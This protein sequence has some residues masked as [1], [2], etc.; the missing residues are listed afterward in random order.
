MKPEETIDFHIRWA[1]HSIARL[2]NIEAARLGGSMSVGY[3]LLNID[4]EKGCP[5][6]KLGTKMGME[7][8]SLTRTLKSMEKKIEKKEKKANKSS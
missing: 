3:V 7:P 4:L 5:S 6:T 1:W 8:R 2:Y